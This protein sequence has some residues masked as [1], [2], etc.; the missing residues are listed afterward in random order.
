MSLPSM[1]F[2][3]INDILKHNW[4]EGS[5]NDVFFLSKYFFTHRILCSHQFS[6]TDNGR[7][8]INP[9]SVGEIGQRQGCNKGIS[10]RHFSSFQY[11]VAVRHQRI[12]PQP[13]TLWLFHKNSLTVKA[14]IIFGA[15]PKQLRVLPLFP[16]ICHL[17]FK[18]IFLLFLF[19]SYFT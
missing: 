13:K 3:Y 5:W 15:D 7:F 16:W 4:G 1:V 10:F 18:T 19:H 11:D 8:C 9:C 12:S 14:N 17:R 6:A 2:Q